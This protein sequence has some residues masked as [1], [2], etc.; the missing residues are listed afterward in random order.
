[1]SS[2][3]RRLSLF[4]YDLVRELCTACGREKFHFVTKGEDPAPTACRDCGSTREIAELSDT[5]IRR[6]VVRD[7]GEI[8]IAPR[9]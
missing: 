4:Y 5:S 3:T 6:L 2:T 8:A 7:S 1:M 9:R